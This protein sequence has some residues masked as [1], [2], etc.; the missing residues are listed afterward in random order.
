MEKET[1]GNETTSPIR[2]K[3]T[4]P[5]TGIVLAGGKSFRM[6]TDKG[7]ARLAG[8]PLVEY[9]INNLKPLC[10]NILIGANNPEYEQFGYAVIPDRIPGIGPMGGIY[11]CL[12]ASGTK[13]NIALSCD[14]PLVST[15]ALQCLLLNSREELV[16]LPWYRDDHYE[17]LCAIYHKEMAV[18]L[19]DYIDLHIY[20]LPVVFSQIPV[21]RIPV[22]D[23]PECFNDWTFYNIN[24]ADDLKKLEKII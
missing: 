6:Q 21:N 9:A 14:T 12:K 18:V 22:A 4:M 23:Y 16:T 5:I 2:L 17:P 1:Q 8:R 24:T 19:K 3:H 20:K 11:S 15:S 13:I 10:S 7:L